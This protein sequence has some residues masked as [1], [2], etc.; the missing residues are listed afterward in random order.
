[1]AMDDPEAQL[2]RLMENCVTPERLAEGTYCVKH[3]G[4]ARCDVKPKGEANHP[5]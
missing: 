5:C 1:M 3:T 2:V 4:E